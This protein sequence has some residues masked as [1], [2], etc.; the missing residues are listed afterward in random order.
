MVAASQMW[1]SHAGSVSDGSPGAP[2]YPIWRFFP[3]A[4][5]DGETE[6][7]LRSFGI[8]SYSRKRL[9]PCRQPARLPVADLWSMDLFR[10]ESVTLRAHWVLVVVDQC[11]RRIIGFGV[12][13]G[14]VDGVALCRM[15][16][17]TIRGQRSLPRYVSSDHDPLYKFHPWQANLRVLEVTEIKTVPCVPLSHPFVERLIG[18]I[19]REYLD[20]M[21]FW[22]SADLENKPLDF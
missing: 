21:W 8:S 4:N 9:R 3:C 5:P 1:E 19:R 18:T 6:K 22:T 17:R 11:T 13:A 20:H 15:F 7:L 16:N 14:T 12:H 10:C 2:K